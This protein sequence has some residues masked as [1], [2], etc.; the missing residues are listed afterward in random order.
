MHAFLDN[1]LTINGNK[2]REQLYVI[3][4]FN[5]NFLD[6]NSNSVAKFVQKLD[7]RLHLQPLDGVQGASHEA[8][9]QLDHCFTNVPDSSGRF[10]EIYESYFSDHAPLVLHLNLSC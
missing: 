6:T 1:T 10:S 7:T 9:S 2:I 3:G 5:I 4:D 8:G